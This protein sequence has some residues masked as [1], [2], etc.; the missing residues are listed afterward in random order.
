[1]DA[2]EVPL[3]GGDVT[4]GVVRVGDTVRR[5][6]G[7]HSA[8]VHAVLRHL[9]S[10]GFDGAPRLLGVDDRGRETLTF[11]EGEVAGRPWPAWVGDEAR[12]VSVAR[13][14]RRLDD[15][16]A[17]LGLPGDASWPAPAP[18]APEP[19]FLGHL[20]VTPENT[21][22]RGGAAVAL[23]DFDLVRPA[24]RVDEVVNLLQWWGAWMPVEDRD[25]AMRAV[26]PVARGRVLADA[27]GLDAAL[28]PHVVPVAVLTAQ[29]TWPRMR[30]RAERLGGGWARMWDAG[31]G[32]AIRR[33]ERWLRQ[34]ADAL[35]DALTDALVRP[36]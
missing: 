14:L 7:E 16:L 24:S 18:G 35:T 4:E 26:D 33:R 19:T 27:Y 31:V 3:A 6:L 8:T 20:D 10:V 23:I 13:L 21:V 34:N 15:A 30:E 12:A 9:E 1:M 11:L 2:E 17:P 32:D 29:R 25:P 36:T 22:F 28:R 5:P